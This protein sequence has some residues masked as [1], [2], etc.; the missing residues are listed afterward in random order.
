MNWQDFHFIRPWWLLMLL[1]V[2]AGLARLWWRRASDSAWRGVVSPELLPHLLLEEA[3]RRPRWPL[4]LVFAGFVLAILAVAGPTW[5][6]LPQPVFSN[7]SSLVIALDLSRSMDARDIKPSRLQSARFKVEDILHLRKEGQTAL[8][9]FAGAAFTVSPLTD[10]A[11]TIISQLPALTTDIMPVQG[12]NTAGA[13]R[14]ATELLQ[15]ARQ[16]AGQI[17]LVTDGVN[18]AASVDEARKAT[19]LGYRI[20]VLA[21]GTEEGAPIPSRQGV[22]KDA[23]GNIVVAGL[24]LEALAEVARAGQGRFARMSLDDTDIR[25]LDLVAV[26]QDLT[27]AGNASDQE[28]VRWR[29]FGPWLLLPLLPLAALVF[30]KGML[31]L[32]FVMV[33]PFPGKTEAGWWT[34]LWYRPDQQGQQLLQQKK[35][36]QAAQAFRNPGW[37]ASALYR[38][39]EYE[40]AEKLW[41]E[42]Q[43]ADSRYNLGNAL[44]REGKL[45]EAIAAYEEALT[46]NPELE[47]AKAN[48]DLLKKILEQQQQ[49]QQQQQQS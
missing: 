43:D 18:L 6:R 19:D 15:Q 29:D 35:P 9:A 30:R 41:S 37:K 16:P 23:Q 46:M 11:R 12:S 42:E 25:S 49:Q 21:V 20:S 34:D 24:N 4:M 48:R 17:L 2:L 36:Q 28:I 13:I 22:I 26:N 45:E 27:R 8:I 44:A 33:M 1:P 40:Q 39:G 5:E 32:V 10:D 3:L 47:D 7:Q 38:S 31:I 14:L